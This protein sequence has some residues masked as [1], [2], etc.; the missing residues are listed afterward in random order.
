MTLG[1]E[2]PQRLGQ[3]LFY[4]GR[5]FDY[6]V[7]RLQLPNGAVGDWECILHPGGSMA[8][9]V[10]ADGQFVLVKQYRFAM[11]GRL[12]EF[13][14]GTVEKGEDPLDT[15][16]REIQEE[17]GYKADT[18]KKLGEFPNAPGYSDEIIYAYLA[19]GLSELAEP[20]A[21]D[22]DEDIEV[23]LMSAD[24]LEKAIL[25]GTPM[26]AKTIAAFYM[27]RAYL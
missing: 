9:P 8:V 12:L 21:L 5:K 2:L 3:K 18:W 16:Q 26:D 4:A 27:A 17:T 24:A 15:I 19:T 11:K 1:Q 6:E 22:E 13:P 7:A 23:V 14:A 10:T 25:Q 20:L